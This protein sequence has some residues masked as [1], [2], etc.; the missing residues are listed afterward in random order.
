M[1]NSAQ[2]S[3]AIDR[4]RVGES[5]DG[6]ATSLGVSRKTITRTLLRNGH[7]TRGCHDFPHERA[8][9]GKRKYSLNHAAFDDPGPDARYWIGYLMADGNVFENG[10]GRLITLLS[11]D[12]EHIDKFRSFLKSSHPIRFRLRKLTGR[13]SAV[14]A[15]SSRQIAIALARFGVVERKSLTAKVIGGLEMDRDFWRGVIDGDGSI[16]HTGP[17]KGYPHL[18]YPCVQLTGSRMIVEQFLA[19]V[20]S[21]SPDCRCSPRHSRS[22]FCC[23]VAGRHA[24]AT[25]RRLYGGCTV[26]LDRKNAKAQKIIASAVCLPA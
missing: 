3:A 20:R 21:I 25:L 15:F 13:R 7:F 8:S 10:R 4:Y 19:F 11:D 9:V 24:T 6:V 16:G 5:L 17:Q 26:A 12:I 23:G 2:E 1:L 18:Q 14:L 22:V